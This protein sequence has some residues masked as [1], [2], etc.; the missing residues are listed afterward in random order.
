M[1]DKMAEKFICESL[2]NFR[3][4]NIEKV[5]LCHDSN[6]YGYPFTDRIGDSG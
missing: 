4:N 5:F 2:E 6:S 1:K 3:K